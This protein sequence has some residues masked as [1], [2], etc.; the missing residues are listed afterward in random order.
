MV[1]ALEAALCR[2]LSF[3][4]AVQDALGSMQLAG[5]LQRHVLQG[6]TAQLPAVDV[7]DLPGL[8]RQVAAF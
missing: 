6:L 7:E 2:D 3:I 5:H 4:A 8:V 1:D